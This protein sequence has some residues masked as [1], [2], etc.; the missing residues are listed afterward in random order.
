MTFWIV[1]AGVLLVFWLLGRIR[2]GVAVAYSEAGFFLSVKI[3]PARIQILPANTLKKEKQPKKPK[4]VADQSAAADDVVKPK[5]NVKDTVS[6][7]LRYLPLVGEA[8]GQL[9]RKI[10]IDRVELHI[11]WGVS[12]P[13]DA[14]T[15][16]GAGN[17][18]MGILWPAVE[19]N[20]KV[21]EYDLS[22]DVDF[23]RTKPEF[24][25]DAR[26]T[27]TI[28][29]CFSLALALGIKTLKIYLGIRREKSEKT[30]NEK[31]V[32]A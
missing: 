10:R 16:Y 12:D 28:G 7:V 19:H 31:A 15:G 29:Q 8:A 14:A 20:F 4:V 23:E 27:I 6:N 3:G 2:L 1:L 24:K 32:Q 9:K 21:K 18:A 25:G 17:V 26:V 11:I 13:A 5:R 30:E 22:V